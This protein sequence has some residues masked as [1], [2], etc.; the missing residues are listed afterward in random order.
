MAGLER[1]WRE[2]F[3]E[4]EHTCSSGILIIRNQIHCPAQGHARH[5]DLFL[6]CHLYAQNYQYIT[7]QYLFHY[8]L[9]ITINNIEN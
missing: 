7:T 8:L 5:L 3:P 4:I 1:M 9:T 2:C 6:A